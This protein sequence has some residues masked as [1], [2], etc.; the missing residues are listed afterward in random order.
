MSLQINVIWLIP[1]IFS[2][3]ENLLNI[4]RSQSI[5]R[6]NSKI[7]FFLDP[8]EKMENIFAQIYRDLYNGVPD[9][10]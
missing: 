3:I 2:T 1:C 8:F 4:E 7:D 6:K 9:F 5:I 10:I